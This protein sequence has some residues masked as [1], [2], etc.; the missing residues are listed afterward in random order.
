MDAV[1]DN[2]VHVAVIASLSH[3]SFDVLSHD[4]VRVHVTATAIRLSHIT[5]AVLRRKPP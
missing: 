1:K 3:S 2:E 5:T 4:R